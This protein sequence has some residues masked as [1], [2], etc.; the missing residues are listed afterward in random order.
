MNRIFII[1]I[2][3]I[4][5]HCSL[6]TKSG[7]WTKNK[8]VQI[9]EKILKKVFV[10]EEALKKEINKDLQIKLSSK[11]INSSKLDNSNNSGRINF[12]GKLEKISKF[13]FSKIDNFDYFEP[14]IIFDNK[15]IIFFDDKSSIIKFDEMSKIIWK[16]NYYTK[17]EKK[18]KPILSFAK[19]NDTLV[20]TDNIS[21]YYA[22]NI[23][24]GEL[25]WK[26]YN[27]SPFNS[28]IKIYKDKFLVI[29]FENILRCF[30]IKDGEEIWKINSGD[31]F[32]KSE[33]RL[34]L[35]VVKNIVYFNNSLGDIT[36][37]DINSGNAIWQTPTQSSTIYED[38]F[39][40][41][42]SDL[43]ANQKSIIFSNNKNEFYS[44]NLKTGVLNWKQKVNSNVRSTIINELV[45][46]ISNE[47]YFFIIDINTGK[48]I[49]VTNIFKP[50]NNKKKIKLFNQPKIYPEGFIV[51][52]EK[53]YLT[54]SHGRLLIIDISS[55]ILESILKID[56][57]KISRPFIS[58]KEMFIV[59]ENSII[60][61]N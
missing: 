51:G 26:K 29:D 2:F 52:K 54:T 47:G 27:S 16:K 24:S 56:N 15:N 34:S 23:N 39:F 8:K 59:K 60:K 4:Q 9:E 55:G 12:N 46:S 14:E 21:K 36:A 5:T 37:V 1:L 22:I 58:N 7:I 25:L 11:L 3:F 53:V 33:K 32:L 38:A 61:L 6:D 18:L 57:E 48:I 13:K 35:I 43:I 41:K 17:S 44:L 50:F 20:V 40:L 30:S 10:N 19:K 42:T 45:F 28:Q 31:A 49:R